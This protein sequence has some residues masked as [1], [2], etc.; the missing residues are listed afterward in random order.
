MGKANADW[1]AVGRWSIFESLTVYINCVL[2]GLEDGRD[3]TCTFSGFRMTNRDDQLRRFCAL[4]KTV[5]KL[6]L[7]TEVEEKRES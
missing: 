4:T 6:K 7:I 2:P 1:F 5:E 3:M